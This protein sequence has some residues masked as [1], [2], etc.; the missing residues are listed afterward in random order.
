MKTNRL[1]LSEFKLK[2][3]NATTD[4]TSK[5]MGGV[6]ASCHD[7]TGGFSICANGKTTVDD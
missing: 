2:Q 1:S 6:L 5:L 4:K 7:T 3:P